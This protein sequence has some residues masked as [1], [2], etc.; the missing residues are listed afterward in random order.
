M[1][2]SSLTL[3][4]HPHYTVSLFSLLSSLTLSPLLARVAKDIVEW[5][6]GKEYSDKIIS[7]VEAEGVDGAALLA[8]RTGEEVRKQFRV[9]YL[10]CSEHACR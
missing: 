2:L 8:V 9:G 3:S 4:P 1:P 6:R 10:P 7:M 5:L